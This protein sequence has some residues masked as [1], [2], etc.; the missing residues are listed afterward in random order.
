MG[1]SGRGLRIRGAAARS[2]GTVPARVRLGA[3]L[4]LTVFALL[5]SAA[6]AQA[7]DYVYWANEHID[8][9][10]VSTGRCV[11]MTRASG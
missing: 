5:G 4:A 9:M 7:S 8:A 6:A 11:W 3:T 10:I 2:V 1:G